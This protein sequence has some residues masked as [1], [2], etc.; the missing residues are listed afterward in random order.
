MKEQDIKH[1]VIGVIAGGK[2]PKTMEEQATT[3]IVGKNV[4]DTLKRLDL[5]KITEDDKTDR[6]T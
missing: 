5:L 3:V 6:T 2:I 4:F 1:L